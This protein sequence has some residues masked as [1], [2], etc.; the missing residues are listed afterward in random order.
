M[1]GLVGGPL[2]VEGLRPGLPASDV[3]F[4][5]FLKFLA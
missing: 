1:K 4:H 3:K 5:E 2:L